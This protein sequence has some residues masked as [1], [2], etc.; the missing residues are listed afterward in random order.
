[1][2]KS[3]RN[4][5]SGWDDDDWDAGDNEISLKEQRM[6]ARRKKRKT[7]TAE[8]YANIDDADDGNDN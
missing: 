1:M 3:F 5:R 7:K 4:F 8:K 2:A 6:E